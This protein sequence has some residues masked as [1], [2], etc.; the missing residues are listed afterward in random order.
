MIEKLGPDGMSSDED[1]GRGVYYIR[2]RKWRHP[3]VTPFVRT[4]DEEYEDEMD[5][6]AG[7]S[8]RGNRPHTRI[9]PPNPQPS[10]DAATSANASAGPSTATAPR[11]GADVL[12]GVTPGLPRTLYDPTWLASLTKVQLHRLK[13]QDREYYFTLP[14]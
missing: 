1:M 8:R 6:C 14:Q 7:T 13:V 5:Y 10:S 9:P 3:H 4:A 2:P 12:K 11:G